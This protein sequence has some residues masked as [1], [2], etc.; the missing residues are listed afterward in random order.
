ME[1]V[2]SGLHFY[3][4]KPW[5]VKKYD[6]H[7]FFPG[8]AG[9]GLKGVDFIAIQKGRLLLIEIKNYRRR[10]AWQIENPVQVILD[11]PEAFAETITHKAEDTLRGIRAIGTYYQRK[12]LYKLSAPLLHLLPT[13]G[14]DFLF[15]IRAF[16]LSNQRENIQ[17]VLW[18][19]TEQERKQLRRLVTD[20][21]GKN[22]QEMI[23]KT[24][25][26]D[27]EEQSLPQ[28]IWVERVEEW[29]RPGY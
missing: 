1:F 5:V 24:T 23:G 19:E 17:F 27:C 8:L 7:R 25:V 12:W 16:K 26:I 2:E 29:S 22:L 3:F 6:A 18:M 20:R 9:A 10:R 4:E 15:W 21:L 11:D 14:W 13:N 28:S